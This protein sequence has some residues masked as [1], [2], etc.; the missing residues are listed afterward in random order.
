M[1]KEEYLSIINQEAAYQGLA[2]LFYLRGNIKQ[3]TTY[4]DKLPLD[5]RNDLWRTLTHP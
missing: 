1:T 2:T 3:A 5:I 4:A